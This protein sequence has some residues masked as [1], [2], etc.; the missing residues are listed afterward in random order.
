[1]NATTLLTRIRQCTII[2]TVIAATFLTT[3]TAEAKAGCY[4][5]GCNGKGPVAMGCERDAKTL[6]KTLDDGVL[7]ELRYSKACHAR[8]A[9]TTNV[10]SPKVGSPYAYLGTGQVTYRELIRHS[11]DRTIW[12]FMWT[13]KI[14][15]CGGMVF[16]GERLSRVC[17]T[18]K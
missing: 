17:T 5:A 7:V 2:G 9:R 4:G 13:G 18:A 10:N 3:A 12:S 15:A 14:R 16:T 1:M 8:W 11:L 6:A